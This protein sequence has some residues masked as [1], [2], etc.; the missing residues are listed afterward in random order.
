MHTHMHLMH[1][2]SAS[3]TDPTDAKYLE[4]NRNQNVGR[5]MPNAMAAQQNTGGAL[6]KSSL[7]PYLVPC[8]KV[9]LTLAARVLCS[10]AANI[11]ERITW[12]QSEFCSW[13]T[14]IRVQ[15]PP[16]MYIVYQPRRRP[17]ILQSFVDLR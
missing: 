10:N 8:R 1:N 4:T 6:C 15:E 11:G 16:K 7:I 3:P 17:N 2:H 5:P 12:T 14:S 9:W 13:Q